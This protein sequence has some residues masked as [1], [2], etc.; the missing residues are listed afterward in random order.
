MSIQITIVKTFHE[1]SE[2]AKK[3]RPYVEQCDVYSPESAFSTVQ[4]AIENEDS[5]NI[6]LQ[7]AEAKCTSCSVNRTTRFSLNSA[8][9]NETSCTE[10]KKQ[11][12]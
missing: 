11:A 3:L 8:R 7:M 6:G 12:G 9:P 1:T 2:D 4:E 5:W 10:T